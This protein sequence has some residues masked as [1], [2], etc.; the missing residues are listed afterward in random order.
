MGINVKRCV[1]FQLALETTGRS[2]LGE[3]DSY[4]AKMAPIE[5]MTKF[6]GIA[7]PSSHADRADD[8]GILHS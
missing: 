2:Q 5:L 8:E 4:N 6:S 7:L 3:D 1:S